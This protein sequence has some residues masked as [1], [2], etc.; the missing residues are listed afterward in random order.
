MHVALANA[1][2]SKKKEGN[3]RTQHTFCRQ[4]FMLHMTKFYNTQVASGSSRS[5]ILKN[6]SIPCA[7]R[8]MV[9]HDHQTRHRKCSAQHQQCIDRWGYLDL[10]FGYLSH[11]PI[12]RYRV[13]KTYLGKTSMLQSPGYGLHQTRGDIRGIG[14]RYALQSRVEYWNSLHDIPGTMGTSSF[15]NTFS[16]P[17]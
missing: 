6:L 12:S 1:L 13:L 14:L 2:S 3:P 16:Q 5:Q 7:R 11:F 10:I 8:H 9:Q 17:S 4:R 15:L